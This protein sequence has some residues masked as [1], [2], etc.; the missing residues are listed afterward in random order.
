MGKVWNKPSAQQFN[1]DEREARQMS[2]YM[3]SA[4]IEK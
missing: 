4:Y 1:R 2:V 3:P